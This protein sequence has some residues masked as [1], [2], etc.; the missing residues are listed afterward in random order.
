MASV[1]KE[2]T[3]PCGSP[4]ER[5]IGGLPGSTLPR[6]FASWANGPSGNG[7]I[8]VSGKAA[9]QNRRDIREVEPQ[10]KGERR[11]GKVYSGFPSGRATKKKGPVARPAPVTCFR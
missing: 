4:M 1:M 11:P 9:S 7:L 2:G 6:S 10:E 3:W 8:K 5:L